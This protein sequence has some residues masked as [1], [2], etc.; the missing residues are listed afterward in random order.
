MPPTSFHEGR[1]VVFL[2]SDDAGDLIADDGKRITVAA[3]GY[4]PALGIVSQE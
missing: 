3:L 4:R 1:R 2:E